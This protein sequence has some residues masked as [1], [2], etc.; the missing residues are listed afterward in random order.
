MSKQITLASGQITRSPHD[1]IRVELLEL[2]GEP[3][4]VRVTWPSQATIS[5]PAKH[6][7][8]AATAMRILGNGATELA[9]LKAGRRR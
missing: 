6:A 9:R 7:E 2:V 3:A 8:A 4:T 1:T 5:S